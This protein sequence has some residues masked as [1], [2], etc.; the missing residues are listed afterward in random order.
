MKPSI[1]RIVHYKNTDT[2]KE[3][4]PTAELVPAIITGVHSYTCVSLTVFRHS[5]TDY[6]SSV[7]QG[8]EQGQ[9][10]WPARVD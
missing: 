6:K 1:G 2:E 3:F 4:P 8:P 9:W 5:W 10:D 7:V